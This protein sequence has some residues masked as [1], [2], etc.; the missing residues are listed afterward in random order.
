MSEDRELGQIVADLHAPII[1]CAGCL[2]Q[3]AVARAELTMSRLKSIC[4]INLAADGRISNILQQVVNHADNDDNW[5]LF[6]KRQMAKP[7]STR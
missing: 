1:V 5:I 7:Y 2:V 3:D 4:E 6:V